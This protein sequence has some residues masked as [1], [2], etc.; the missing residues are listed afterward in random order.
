MVNKILSIFN[1]KTEEEAID[2]L[3][4]SENGLWNH[5][6]IPKEE[7]T[8]EEMLAQSKDSFNNV[9]NKINI[10]K[11]K[12]YFNKNNNNNLLDNSNDNVNIIDNKIKAI[13]E[14]NEDICEICGESKQFHSIKEF[15][16][17]NINNNKFLEIN[18]IFKDNLIKVENISEEK[19]NDNFFISRENEEEDENIN[20]N[21]CQICMDELD[22]PVK[23]EKCNHKFCHECFH[24]Y[25]VNLIKNNKIDNIP[26]PKNKCKNKKLSEDFFSKYL[27]KDEYL[28]Y[29]LF[30]AQ[31]EIARDSKKVFCPLCDSYATIEENSL[32]IIDSNSPNYVK[33][34]LKCQKGH[35]FCTCGRPI[36]EGNCYHDGIEF[37]KFIDKEN[38]KKC[39]K[40]GFLIKKNKGCNHMICG[41]PT[42][43]YEFCWL[44]LQESTPDHYEF[45]PCA[46]KQFE[47]TESILYG[48]PCLE[49]LF[50]V[51][52]VIVFI[53][54]IILMFAVPVIN[55][56]INFFL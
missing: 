2:Y 18:N 25:L 16:F 55:F 45:G 54:L 43:K 23:I 15:N 24:S 1:I 21:K 53:I 44:C 7:E 4:K 8:E 32:Q 6:F 20:Q 13:K 51:L 22:E 50:N 11:E 56:S 30:K 40:C 26:C 47:D 28:K 31:N 35:E 33:S 38:I 41:N 52:M 14:P 36:H 48:H 46:G 29:N 34:T 3:I 27:T 37:K 49:K 9:L 19:I 39:P 17:N 5:P 42:C 10:I 12:I